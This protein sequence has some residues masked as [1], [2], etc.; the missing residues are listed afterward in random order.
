MVRVLVPRYGRSQIGRWLAQRLGR[1]HVPVQLDEVGSEV[2]EACDG[3][4]PVSGISA[5]L[6][7][8]FGDSFD[9]DH[10]RL[11]RYLRQME[12]QRLIRWD[13]VD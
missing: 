5:R 6:K 7:K 9:P 3:A 10:E 1:P 8:R 12:R 13:A 4:T 11:A 2:W